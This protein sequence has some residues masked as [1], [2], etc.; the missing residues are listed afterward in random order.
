MLQFVFDQV[1]D[2]KYRTVLA[3]LIF[4]RMIKNR[5]LGNLKI[6]IYGKMIAVAKRNLKKVNVMGGNSGN[7]IF[8]ATNDPPQNMVVSTMR[9]I[10]LLSSQL[11]MSIL[12]P[13]PDINKAGFLASVKS[14]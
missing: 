7:A 3:T 14:V 11:A 13:I 12:C 9:S 6:D 4:D 5:S 2:C 8:P 1:A 10:V